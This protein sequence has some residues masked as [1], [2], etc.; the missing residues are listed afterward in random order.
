MTALFCDLVGSV[1][2]TA[3]LDPEDMMHVMD[4]Y[5]GACNDVIGRHGGYIIQ[6]MGDGVLAY[7]GYPR[8]NEDDAVNAV[9]SGLEL[10]D[11]VAA[12]DLPGSVRLQVRIGIA[13]GLV[14]VSDLVGQGKGREAALIGETPNL[15]A[16]LQSV[17][18]PNSVVVAKSTRE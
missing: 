14:V 7:F 15:A 17:A 13:T 1:K 3:R 2:L 10:R 8:A 18:A 6:Y 12:L 9:R 4:A 5:L 16:R 11:A